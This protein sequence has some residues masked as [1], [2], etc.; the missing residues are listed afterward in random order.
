MHRINVKTVWSGE[1]FQMVTE[2]KV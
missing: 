1:L 2:M